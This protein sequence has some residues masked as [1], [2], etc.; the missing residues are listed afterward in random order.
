M[1]GL[2][3]GI[4]DEFVNNIN[5]DKKDDDRY[6]KEKGNQKE[7]GPKFKFCGSLIDQMN[8]MF[9][10]YYLDTNYANQLFNE[11]K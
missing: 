10:T 6:Q 9:V 2:N 11:L 5:D 4:L 3:T 1:I 7:Y 8:I